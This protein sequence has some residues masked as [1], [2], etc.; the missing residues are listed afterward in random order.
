MITSASA[1]ASPVETRKLPL[2]H[3]TIA[4]W[5]WVRARIA[6]AVAWAWLIVDDDQMPARS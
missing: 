4:I 2:G 3:E 1:A 6:V 5:A